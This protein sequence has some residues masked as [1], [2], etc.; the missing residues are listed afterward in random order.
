MARSPEC[1][2]I[3]A[4]LWEMLFH[5]V[6]F[7]NT[8]VTWKM[9]LLAPSLRCSYMLTLPLQTAFGPLPALPAKLQRLSP[10]F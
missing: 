2:S 1:R 7:R 4:L 10:V 9:F 8:A 5:L 6:T 3:P